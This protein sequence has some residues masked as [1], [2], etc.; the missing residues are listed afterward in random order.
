MKNEAAYPNLEPMLSG[1]VEMPPVTSGLRD[2]RRQ[3]DSMSLLHFDP[4]CVTGRYVV[5]S[6]LL[7]GHSTEDMHVD[8]LTE[9]LCRLGCRVS[10]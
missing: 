4:N 3:G 7:M 2:T 6:S 1:K 8:N 10:V 9:S 5:S